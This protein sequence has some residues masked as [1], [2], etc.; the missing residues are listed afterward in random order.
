MRLQPITASAVRSGALGVFGLAC[1]ILLS[2]DARPARAQH[3][4]KDAAAWKGL[5]YEPAAE[6][7]NCHNTPRPEDKAELVL[8]TEYPI[9]KTQDKH[10]QAY[11]VLEGPR[12]K[13]MGEILG[14]KDV[15][16][17]ETGCLNCHALQNLS[18]ENLANGVAKLD[19]TDG[20]SC[21]GCHGPSSK[22]SIAHSK[23]ADWR[24]K[25]S[26][27]DKYKEGMRD[28]RDPVV[29]AELC[30]SCHIGNV[31]EGKVV[32]HAMF[33][34]GHPPLPP[35]E[36]SAFSRN[37]PQHWRDPQFVPYFKP[38]GR[39]PAVEANFH[40]EAMAFQRSRFALAGSVVALRETMR[41]AHDQAKDVPAERWPDVAMAHSDCY[42]CHHELK[43]PSY[44]QV[45]GF[46][47]ELA[48]RDL[49]RTIPGRPLIR[50]WPNA[51]GQFSLNFANKS[52]ES[53]QFEKLLRGV[54]KA[55]NARPFGN[56]ADIRSETENVVKWCD[57]FLKVLNTPG[58]YTRKNAIGFVNQ[59]AA[60][61]APGNKKGATPDYETAR[62]IAFVVKAIYEEV[63]LDQQDKPVTPERF[64]D[65]ET[66]TNQ[67]FEALDRSL[68][69]QPY[70]KRTERTREVLKM[71]AMKANIN[72]D[73]ASVKAFS[74]FAAN[75]NA[76]DPL[77]MKENNFVTAMNR[78]T[79]V[80]FTAGLKEKAVVDAL[81]KLSDTEEQDVL[82]AIKGY[83][84]ALFKDQ[85]A[86][87]AKS[88]KP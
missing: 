11:A 53:D 86:K 49:I 34:A 29:R 23:P 59:L 4:E 60:I 41:L 6:C 87:V 71:V 19:E 18:K 5:K 12:G 66:Q 67:V 31:G 15:L 37:L 39:K 56:P 79:N 74:D 80:Q 3:P 8:Q 26:A 64:R 73:D 51:L 38:E 40:L 72:P 42:S 43:S 7:R 46:G 50:T 61:Y 14:N 10:A 68:D 65:V 55:S 84:P 85:L 82:D 81:Q 57:D 52:A 13:R 21:G 70:R 75:V 45:R 27:A 9:W 20:I 44:R 32:T 63:L 78:L 77:K 17:P 83:D 25:L 16:Q 54:A 58:L 36:V 88:L 30:V 69:L 62:Q 1:A 48:G 22:W 76:G 35:M 24:D 33:A 28:L 47:Y 2:L